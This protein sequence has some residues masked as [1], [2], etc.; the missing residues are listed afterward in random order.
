MIIN[1]WI[2]LQKYGG[3][4]NI[5]KAIRL[6]FHDGHLEDEICTEAGETINSLNI[7]RAVASL[8]QAA[9]K[10]TEEVIILYN[11]FCMST[12]YT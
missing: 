5:D 10:D 12:I 3:L 11:K 9:T 8:F 4:E 1:I 2:I 7:K 6:N